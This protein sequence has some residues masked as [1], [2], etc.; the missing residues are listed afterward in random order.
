MTTV[1]EL[2]KKLEVD[3]GELRQ[4]LLG[5]RGALP[6]FLSELKKDW[7]EDLKN[8]RA[9]RKK[10][11][12]FRD[13]VAL[14][15]SH[16]EIIQHSELLSGNNRI[17]TDESKRLNYAARAINILLKCR[18]SKTPNR[19]S[20]RYG[21]LLLH[22]FFPT[23]CKAPLLDSKSSQDEAIEAFWA[24]TNEGFGKATESGKQIVIASEAAFFLGWTTECVFKAKDEN[25]FTTTE[26]E[27]GS[28]IVIDD[29]FFSLWK[30]ST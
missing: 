18:R 6:R 9:A 14:I 11:E 13:V 12:R 8:L 20:G 30:P 3:E 25:I 21:A 19:E 29:V 5:G 24:M 28:F 22:H 27:G 15:D 2:L 26:I 17:R 1:L 16:I 23:E 4:F 10:V 7:K